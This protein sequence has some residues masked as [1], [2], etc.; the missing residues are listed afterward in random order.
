MVRLSPGHPSGTERRWS[1]KGP[2][3]AVLKGR[4][5]DRSIRKIQSRPTFLLGPALASLARQRILGS[6]DFSPLGAVANWLSCS[7]GI[8]Y[9]SRPFIMAPAM[10]RVVFYGIQPG[11][12]IPNW[13]VGR[14]KTRLGRG[15]TSCSRL[16]RAAYHPNGQST[17]LAGSCRTTCQE[18]YVWH[19][20]LRHDSGYR[21]L[22]KGTPGNVKQNMSDIFVTLRHP[23]CSLESPAPPRSY[24]AA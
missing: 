18:K 5:S 10:I 3:E 19:I 17:V 23:N 2:G 4:P 13:N 8:W 21:T 16:R 6:R 15:W 1:S 22:A 11:W 9:A 20:F 24:P 7:G 12:N 14:S